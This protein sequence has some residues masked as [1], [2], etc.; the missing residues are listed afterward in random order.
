MLNPSAVEEVDQLVH[1]SAS[2]PSDKRFT[3]RDRGIGALPVSMT[4]FMP[5]SHG[6]PEHVRVLGLARREG[7]IVDPFQTK[8]RVGQTKGCEIK[9]SS[10]AKDLHPAG[11]A[12]VQ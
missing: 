4:S 1:S 6:S 3:G 9:L 8:L 5:R 11:K 12:A 10:V 2:S 7:R